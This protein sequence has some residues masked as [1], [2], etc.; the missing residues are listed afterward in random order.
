[1]VAVTKIAPCD[2][3][4]T[5]T[6]ETPRSRRYDDGKS[7]ACYSHN[8]LFKPL[9]QPKCEGSGSSFWGA[10]FSDHAPGFVFRATAFCEA[11][12]FDCFAT[13][14]GHFN[15]APLP[16]VKIK[17]R[18]QSIA[19]YATSCTVTMVAVTKEFGANF[20]CYSDL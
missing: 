12:N 4:V 11:G 6:F 14:K 2:K 13:G 15:S 8:H 7:P 20:L 16:M 19:A 17:G 18:V 5:A 1:M 9:L 10:D 3:I